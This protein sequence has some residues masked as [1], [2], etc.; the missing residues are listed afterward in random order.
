MPQLT[1][2]MWSHSS[3]SSLCRRHDR[4]LAN[5]KVAPLPLVACRV[6]L[7][8]LFHGSRMIAAPDLPVGF[9]TL[10]L[11]MQRLPP[12]PLCLTVQLSTRLCHRCQQQ[13]TDESGD[14]LAQPACRQVKKIRLTKQVAGWKPG[15]GARN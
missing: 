6:R 7:S 3:R 12:Q 2:N 8:A 10:R 1:A 13:G 15:K 4:V 9:A 5:L 11:A 14:F